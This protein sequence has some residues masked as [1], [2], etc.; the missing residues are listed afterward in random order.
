MDEVLIFY[1]LT[2]LFLLPVFQTSLIVVLPVLLFVS[3]CSFDPEKRTKQTQP[4]FQI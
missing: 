2:C 3:A 1:S 4:L